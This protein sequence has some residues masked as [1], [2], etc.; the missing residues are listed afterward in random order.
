MVLA[1][2][3][4]FGVSD[5]LHNPSNP[6]VL[7]SVIIPTLGRSES[8][9]TCLES[10][11]EQTFK[12]FEVV[13][14]T[15]EGELA[16]LRNEGSRRARG[17]YL[18]FIDDDVI[19]S[20]GWL[21]AI[22]QIFD[23]HGVGG[24]SGVSYIKR[25]FKRNR[26]LFKFRFIKF[27]YDKFFTDG[28]QYLPGHITKAG[29]WTTGASEEDCEYEGTV[30][31]LEA[32]NMAFRADIFNSCGGFDEN[33]RGVGDWSEPDL[34]FRI[35]R[36]GYQLWFSRNAKLEHRP[37]KTGA[38]KK[39]NDDSRNRM[40]NYELFSRKWIE[41]SFKHFLYKLFLRTYYAFK[42]IE[43]YINFKAR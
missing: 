27:F 3:S 14:V 9:K 5:Y 8:L 30:D 11:K 18:I 16:K 43:R 1:S 7:C 23:K 17:K 35:R 32:C 26:D 4:V 29:A 31:F 33:Y 22:V 13:L 19:C 6:N 28:R 37:S 21:Q 42:T 12:D 2:D 24:G 36:A 40:E 20:S 38:F 15:E 10:L 25:E 34:S 41:P 39:R